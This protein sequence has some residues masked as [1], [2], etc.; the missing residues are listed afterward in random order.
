MPEFGFNVPKCFEKAFRIQ[1]RRELP[2]EI[3]PIKV[4]IFCNFLIAT[5]V[6]LY[7]S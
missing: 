1:F 7:I 4:D 6:S 5:G 2:K 3:E